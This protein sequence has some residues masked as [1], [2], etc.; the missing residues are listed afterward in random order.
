MRY[1]CLL[2]IALCCV[3]FCG[4]DEAEYTIRMEPDGDVVNRQITYSANAPDDVRARFKELYDKQID[5][6]TFQGS[7]GETLPNDVG[8]FGRYVHLDNPMGHVYV[9]VERFQGQDNQARQAYY[10]A[11]RK[12]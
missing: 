3:P 6:N 7:F 10:R 11:R 12:Q 2:L 5:P 4:C 9:Y 8:G 1:K